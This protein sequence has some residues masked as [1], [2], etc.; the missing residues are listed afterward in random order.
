MADYQK[1]NYLNTTHISNNL[2]LY[3]SARSGFFVFMI[4][5]PAETFANLVKPGVDPD[6]SEPTAENGQLY[7]GEIAAEAIKLNVVK[8]SVPNFEIAEHEYR[9]GND[10]VYFAGVPTFADGSITVNDVIG[11]ETKNIFYAWQYLAYNPHTR[12]GGRMKDYKKSCT[13]IEYTQDLQQIR[14]WTLEGCWVK[15]I[16]EGEFDKENDDK[17]QMTISIRY[18]RA[19]MD[20]VDPELI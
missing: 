16:E 8:A 10:V 6:A 12:K 15:N 4:N 17:R 7:V 19:I 20:P 11:L 13:L 5:N 3:E 9:I 14:S 1:T 18:D 2:R